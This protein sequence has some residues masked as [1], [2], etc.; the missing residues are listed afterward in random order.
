MLNE[1]NEYR[2]KAVL[3]REEERKKNLEEDIKYVNDY[4]SRMAKLKEEEDKEK[5]VK[6][7]RERDLKEYQKLQYEEKKRQ[8][9]DDFKRLNEDAYKNMQRL[10]NENDDFI[11]YAEYHIEEYK[12]QGKNIRPLLIE[13]KKYKQKYCKQ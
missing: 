8:A 4:N 7:L 3:K 12:K 6:R 1:I 9:M 5:E 10:D 2:E 13:L 11:K